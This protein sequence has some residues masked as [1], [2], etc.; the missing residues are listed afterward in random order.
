M[1]K[2]IIK[3]KKFTF[4]GHESF[5]CKTL[6]L[7]KGYDFLVEKK[8]FNSP[9]AVIDLGV[10]KNMVASIRFWLKAFGIMDDEG[11]T[12]LGNY[13]FD[14]QKG[15]DLFIE[16]LATLWLLHFNLVFNHVASIYNMVFCGVQRER[17]Q[18]DRD[19]V[20]TFVKLKLAEAGKQNVYNE[21]TV[22]KDI[23]VLLQNYVLPHKAQSN[24]DYSSLLMDLD[25]IRQNS[26]YNG[27]FFNVEGK[28]KVVLEIFMY[29]LIK[30]KERTQ[31]NTIPLD[32]IHNQVGLVF[33]M[34]DYETI[35][36]VKQ[37]AEKYKQYMSYNDIAGVRQIQF[38]KDLDW[39]KVL[40]DYYEKSI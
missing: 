9:K 12:E 17:S 10:G 22:K 14:K 30:L 35:V 13:L 24:E 18:F 33:C 5:S 8:D 38:T 28:R 4:S 26:S 15:K 40:D 32:T 39:K 27:Y 37:V 2:N 16:D 23:A 19:Q 1:N 7:R 34:S 11:T 6:W 20:Q 31:D 3:D 29:G 36:M 25:L 21:N